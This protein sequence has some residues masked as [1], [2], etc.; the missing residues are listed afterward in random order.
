MTVFLFSS[1]IAVVSGYL[2]F[3]EEKFFAQIA[4]I[5]GRFCGPRGEVIDFSEGSRFANLSIDRGSTFNR[6]PILFQR[7]HADYMTGQVGGRLIV[8]AYNTAPGKASL[9]RY[10]ECSNHLAEVWEILYK[11]GMGQFCHDHP[12]TGANNARIALDLYAQDM[13]YGERTMKLST[14]RSHW[15]VHSLK[16]KKIDKE[17]YLVML[18]DTLHLEV[19]KTGPNHI[20]NFR[21]CDDEIA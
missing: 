10:K 8:V 3:W 17:N 14:D 20:R 1:L 2:Y 6:V 7:A 16:I 18:D 9:P 13:T 5:N 12:V 15:E 21:K 11:T 4:P 19:S